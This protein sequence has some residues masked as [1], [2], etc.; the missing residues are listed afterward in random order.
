VAEQNHNGCDGHAPLSASFHLDFSS[1][2]KM[3]VHVLC[4]PILVEQEA[5]FDELLGCDGYMYSV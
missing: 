1:P 5:P 3:L 2:V 4:L